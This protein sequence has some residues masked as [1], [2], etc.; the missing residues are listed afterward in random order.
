MAGAF[1]NL[2]LFLP[3]HVGEY[4]HSSSVLT[5]SHGKT[6]RNVVVEKVVI[7]AVVVVHES[8]TVFTVKKFVVV[9]G[10]VKHEYHRPFDAIGEYRCI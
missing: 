5:E 2:F 4:R 8:K 9:F 3:T 10:V 7:T 1:D 6:E